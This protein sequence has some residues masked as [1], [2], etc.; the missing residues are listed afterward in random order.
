[1]LTHE[2]ALLCDLE[3]STL[4]CLSCRSTKMPPA[5]PQ[6]LYTLKPENTPLPR[7]TVYKLCTTR[8]AIPLSQRHPEEVAQSIGNPRSPQANRELS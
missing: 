5:P 2:N 6:S 8:T 3:I 4:S 7:L 1:M